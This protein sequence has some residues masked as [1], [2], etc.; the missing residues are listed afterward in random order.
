V[1]DDA[2]PTGPDADV[3]PARR[4]REDLRLLRQRDLGLVVTSR[5]VSDIGTGMAPIALA[6]GVLSLPGG[7]AR[8]LG[9][10]L[11]CAAIPRLLFF[12]V[13]G[14][15]ADRLDR[16]RLMVAAEWLA[17]AAQLTA[18]TL[19]VT[20][21]ASVPAL[22]ALAAVNG[23]AVALFYPSLTGLVP[24]VA[25]D[26]DLQSANALIRLSS[27]LASILG[28]VLGGALV[29]SVGP[30]WALAVDALTYAVSATLL[31]LVRARSEARP[32]ASSSVLSDLVG[33]WREFSSRR[34]VWLIVLLFS[35]SNMG[36]TAAVAVLGPVRS[37]E[38]YGGAP[39]WA[40]VLASFSAGT[41]AGVLAAM[42]VRP[43][44]PLFVALLAQLV[45]ILP[46][47][48]IAVPL[49]L[50]VVAACAFV[51]G[52]A[53]DV[54][55]VLWQTALQRNVPR[56]ALSRVASYDWL[57]SM[58][59]TPV[60]LAGAGALAATIG[61]SGSIWVCAALGALSS[62]GLL[63]PQVRGLRAGLAPVVAPPPA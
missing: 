58:A 31:A 48:A 6:F 16:A 5:L 51:S 41:V 18:A 47:A 14:V 36:F 37:L 24:Q 1:S 30:G 9:L 27:H 56:D 12:V 32:D 34:W 46:I 7:D 35:L 28:T 44:R 55:E 3:A 33:G 23:V 8:A 4:W 22:A 42:R 38:S 11:L 45:V 43:S 61:L 52:V 2:T 21:H 26:R 54:F 59:L 57:G 10:V 17:A 20:G 15:L 29:A 19:F 40:L 62:L 49:P 53:V 39:G 25:D 13:G 63:D 60:A 50:A